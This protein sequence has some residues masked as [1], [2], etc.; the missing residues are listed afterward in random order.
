MTSVG[1][2]GKRGEGR[3]ERGG[4]DERGEGRGQREVEVG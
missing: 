3:G 2:R 4:G 1:G